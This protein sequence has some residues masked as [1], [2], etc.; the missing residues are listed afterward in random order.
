M[1]IS[2]LRKAIRL[3]Q[4]FPFVVSFVLL[5]VYLLSSMSCDISV[6][7]CPVFGLSLF[8]LVT[9]TLT[10]KRLHVSSW[11]LFFYYLLIVVIIIDFIGFFFPFSQLFFNTASLD[12]MLLV[13][14]G[15]ASFITYLYERFK[16]F[17]S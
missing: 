5:V 15:I 11:A 3:L 17:S 8:T 1:K 6:V 13:S 9:M 12:F 14:G 2:D 10:A 7:M 4:I 16:N